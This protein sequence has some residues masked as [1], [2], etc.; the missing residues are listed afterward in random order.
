MDVRRW[1]QEPIKY[2]TKKEVERFFAQINDIRDLLLFDLMYRHALRRQE[3]AQL[4]LDDFRDDRIWVARVKRGK[5]RAYRLHSRSQLLLRRYIKVRRAD[6]SPY[7]FRSRR[8]TS[9]PMSGAE[10]NRLFHRYAETAGLPADRS[11]VHVLRHSIAVHL[12]SIGWD[13]AAVQQRLGHRHI[14]STMVYFRIT[15]SHADELERAMHRSRG[16]A[17]TGR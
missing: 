14:S 3:A 5:S 10:I 11:H 16:I 17:R 6:G 12:A 9:D 15:D 13:P 1:E 8:R 4:T 7:L 2:L